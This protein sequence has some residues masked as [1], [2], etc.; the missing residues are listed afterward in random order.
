MAALFTEK[1]NQFYDTTNLRFGS[2]LVGPPNG[3]KTYMYNLLS[4]SINAIMHLCGRGEG[5]QEYSINSEE[6]DI[7]NDYINNTMVNQLTNVSTITINP[8]S[9]T[10]EELF[11]LQD[12]MT[13]DWKEGLASNIMKG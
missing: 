11:G 12:G 8:K 9:I 5:Q 2:M 6:F 3:G 7:E 13:G 1:F 10:K 4:K